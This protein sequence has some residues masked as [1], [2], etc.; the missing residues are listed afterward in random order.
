M[1]F[2]VARL[3]GWRPVSCRASGHPAVYK[4]L[5]FGIDLE[6]TRKLSA[7]NKRG[8]VGAH[9]SVPPVVLTVLFHVRT[10]TLVNEPYRCLH[11]STM[12]LLPL[13]RGQGFMG[14]GSGAT[15]AESFVSW[16]NKHTLRSK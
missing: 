10:D 13:S 7:R 12:F 9:Q 2:F 3:G 4:L 6:A 1:C 14:V 11:Q 8:I 15:A 16:H 5:C